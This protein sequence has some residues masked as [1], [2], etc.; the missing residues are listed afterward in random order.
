MEIKFENKPSKNLIDQYCKKLEEFLSAHNLIVSIDLWDSPLRFESYINGKLTEINNFWI[1]KVQVRSP[2]FG[3]LPVNLFVSGIEEEIDERKIWTEAWH[4]QDQI[5]R[6]L[7]LLPSS[8][9]DSNWKNDPYW[10]LWDYLE[11]RNN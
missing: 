6:H 7:N 3:E 11:K 9:N 4:I 10:K 2:K 1:K 8:P 5:Y